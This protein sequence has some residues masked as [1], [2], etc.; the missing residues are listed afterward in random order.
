MTR[1]KMFSVVAALSLVMAACGG[2][3]D[4]ATT[5]QADDTQSQATTSAPATTTDTAAPGTTAA[6]DTTSGPA[7]TSAPGA[8]NAEL[9]AFYAAIDE[10][11]AIDSAQMEGKFTIVGAE[12]LPSDQPM[13]MAFSGAFD[14]T[15]GDFSMAI[16]L[17]GILE[18]AA[19][20]G[21][22]IP[23]EFADL[24]SS[25]EI[26]QIG[27]TAY[28]KFPFIAM[29]LGVETEWLSVPADESEDVGGFTGGFVP[30]NPNDLLASFDGVE[31]SI[32]DLGRETIRGSE[33]T[34]YR[35]TVDAAALAEAD[36]DA[37]ESLGAG[38]LS[39]I[40]EL[41]IHFWI[42][43]DGLLHKFEF[44]VDGADV[45]AE[46]GGEFESMVVTFEI[47]GYNEPVSIEAPDPANVTDAED[48]GDMF[49]DF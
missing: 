15:T 10:T 22:E 2:G 32:E 31:A 29:F 19:G 20:L 36:P 5:T 13:T 6:P 33:V 16:D 18:S 23:P 46:P 34:H 27:D 39:Q 28:I 3:T 12:G 35:V 42:D 41:P 14:N 40:S 8:D 24:F 48:L 9:A 49:G 47:F 30:T 26:R 11:T 37:L 17:G 38:D 25:M 1:A 21:E 7:T 45:I 4:T 44:A 43:D